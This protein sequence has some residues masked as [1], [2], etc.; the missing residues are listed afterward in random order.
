[1]VKVKV[2]YKSGTSRVFNFPN[3]SIKKV[4]SGALQKGTGVVKVIQI[5]NRKVKRKSQRTNAFGFPVV[6]GW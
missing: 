6:R 3:T 4:R 5:K 2:I 1:M